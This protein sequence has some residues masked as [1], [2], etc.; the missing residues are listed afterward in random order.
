MKNIIS[1]FVTLCLLLIGCEMVVDVDVPVKTPKLTVN[2]EFTSDSVWKISVS[3]SKYVLDDGAFQPVNDALVIIKEE[4]Q[5]IDTLTQL[6][7]KPLEFRSVSG[8]K[9]QLSNLYQVEV[10]ASG[11][12]TVK[13]SSSLPLKPVISNPDIT[14]M[15]NNTNSFS[16]YHYLVEFDLYDNPASEDFYEIAVVLM[17]RHYNPIRKDTTKMLQ[18]AYI[19]SDDPAIQNESVDKLIFDDKLF[20]GKKIRIPVKVASYSTSDESVYV[21]VRS[22]TEDLYK[23]TSRTTP[24]ETHLRNLCMFIITLKMALGY[25]PVM[26]K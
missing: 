11:H 22:L 24:L 21:H 12:Q 19:F 4:G 3:K 18:S 14:I 13:A 10:S 2:A 25:F 6:G 7:N 15:D 20:T 9:P 5:V 26:K 1:F 17:R 8:K 23:L 16:D